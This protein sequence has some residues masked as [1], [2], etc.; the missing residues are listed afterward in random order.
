MLSSALVSILAPLLMAQDPSPIPSR[1]DQLRALQSKQIFVFM[2]GWSPEEISPAAKQFGYEV[3]AAPSG[4]DI[5][6][7]ARE[8]EVFSKAG[9]KMLARP[10]IPVKDPFDPEDIDRGCEELAKVIAHYDRNP[11]ILGFT[12]VWG[13]YGEGGFPYDFVFSEKAKAAFNQSMN[14]PGEDLPLPPAEGIPG[15]LRYIK[16]MEF[17]SK[18]L[19]EFRKTCI[20]RMKQVTPKLVGT[21]SEFYPIENYQLNM[22]DAPGADFT[23]YDCSFGDV[24]VDQTIAFAETHGDMQHYKTYDEWRK[25][26]RPLIAKAAG[27][28]V[29]PMAFQFP[30]RRGH[31]TDFL[32]PTTV[33]IDNVTDEYSIR[34]GPD[35]RKLIDAVNDSGPKR[36]VFEPEVAL[37]YQSFAASALPGG[38]AFWFYRG[39]ARQIE[40]ALHQMG[41]NLRVIP[42]EWL[43]TADLARYKLVIVPDPLYLTAPM[44]DN[45]KKAKRVLYSGEYLLAHRDPVSATGDYNS[46]FYAQYATLAENRA[47]S[48]LVLK[49]QIIPSGKLEIIARHS[50]TKNVTFLA[51][52][53][54]PR[55]QAVLFNPLPEDAKVFLK[56]GDVPVAFTCEKDR[57][58]HINNRLFCQA[59]ESPDDALEQAAFKLLRNIVEESGAT[60]RILDHSLA[61]VKESPLY[62][63]YGLSGIIAWN[64]TGRDLTLHLNTGKAIDVPAYGWTSV[65]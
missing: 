2:W 3:M 34:I 9:F 16:W 17:R 61:R 59:W 64:T 63:S 55:D 31:A 10:F 50:L 35:L 41:I 43:E 7:K 19:A 12:L 20:E 13:L 46:G 48:P 57:V 14:T 56:V 49:Y 44:R 60:V 52:R 65:N 33:F 30:M 11:D 53:D 21:W 5:A 24:T 45:L 1:A 51:D 47:G 32:A 18:T 58:I 54:Y 62:G 28:G 40:G 23:M 38:N 39:S 26:E 25:H 15:S 36:R 42:Y 22:G 4:N 27:E 6:G 37:V 29:V 8:V